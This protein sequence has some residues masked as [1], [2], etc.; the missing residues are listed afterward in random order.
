MH[1]EDNL[2]L[3]CQYIHYISIVV[4][5]TKLFELNFLFLLLYFLDFSIPES[6][7]K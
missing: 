1:L 4:E 6:N 7:R 3:Q 2:L 5:L